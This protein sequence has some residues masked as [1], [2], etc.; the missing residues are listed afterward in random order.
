MGS[1]LP[2]GQAAPSSVLLESKRK[3]KTSEGS[4]YLIGT[5]K[6]PA[7]DKIEDEAERRDHILKSLTKLLTPS[8]LP[9]SCCFLPFL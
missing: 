3:S 4:P 8:L 7:E 1:V 9:Q 2:G 6:W 5:N